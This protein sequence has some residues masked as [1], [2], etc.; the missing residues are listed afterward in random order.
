M[1]KRSA[2]TVEKMRRAREARKLEREI[3]LSVGQ[4]EIYRLDSLNWVI[5]CGERMQYYPTFAD[6]VHDLARHA[7]P[8]KLKQSVQHMESELLRLHG[9]LVNRIAVEAKNA[10]MLVNE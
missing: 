8:H 2:E 5:Q 7:L 4:Y 3:V 6:A 10:G 1:A 9:D